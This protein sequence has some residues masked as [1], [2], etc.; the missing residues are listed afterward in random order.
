MVSR[1]SPGVPTMKQ[2]W[3]STPARFAA[4]AKLRLLRPEF[5][6]SVGDFIHGYDK[7]MKPLTDESV[8]RAMKWS[9]GSFLVHRGL[10][11]ATRLAECPSET[12]TLL[13][14]IPTLVL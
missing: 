13:A 6:L 12:A 1:V 10:L 5:V 2:P 4:L 8:V 3:T 7:G 11:P 14:W 9:S